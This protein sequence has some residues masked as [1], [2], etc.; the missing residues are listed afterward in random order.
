[1]S[2][3]LAL[4][5]IAYGSDAVSM[6][7]MTTVTHGDQ[8]PYLEFNIGEPGSLDAELNCGGQRWSLDQRVSQGD[9][10]R[11][12]LSGI[13]E[14]VH[15]CTGSMGMTLD[16]GETLGQ[17]LT[18]KVSSLGLI[19]W[20]ISYDTDYDLDN[21]RFV[22]HSSRP[23]VAATASYIGAGGKQVD[24]AEGDLSDPSAPV[25]SWVTADTIVKVVVEGLDATNFK[26]ILE[27]FPYFYNIPH[28]DPVFGTGSDA[29]GAEQVPKLE[30]TWGKIVEQFELYGSVIEMDLYVAGYTDT[31][32]AAGSN[33]A[34]SE[35][36]AR[37]I[38]GWFK[39]RGFQ[40]KIYYQGFGESALAV[41][42]GD[43]VDEVQNRRVV[44]CMGN[45]TPP[46]SKTLPRANWKRL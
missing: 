21:K 25:F 16:R 35:R 2:V 14:G 18:L 32:G 4:L 33:Q 39:R 10:V 13:V 37:S 7:G 12:T 36:R 30:D 11:L 5:G 40:G 26:G 27:V 29:I 23:L 20:T 24:F 28:D 42:T 44:Y 17:G 46:T 3:V 41:E 43:N 45:Q 19:T 34:L 1:M 9:K 15:D 38:A 6:S 31:M 8:T 22:A